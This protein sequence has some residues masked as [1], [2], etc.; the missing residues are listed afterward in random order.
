[1][2]T[3]LAT[4]GCTGTATDAT[5]GAGARAVPPDG[6]AAVATFA[7]G[8]FWCVESA[9]DDFRGVYSAVSGFAGGEEVDPTYDQVASG[10]TGHAEV[11]RITYDPTE[12]SYRDLLRV[13]W[14]QID[15]TD[16]GGQFADRG[17]QY[18]TA[19][20]YH[21][22]EQRRLAEAS[23]HDLAASG[24]FDA[25]I[26]TEIVPAGPFYPAEAYHQDFHKKNPDRYKSYYRGSGREGYLDR[27]WGDEPDQSQEK[28]YMKP[29]KDEIRERLDDLQ[30]HV[31]QEDGTEP[32]FRNEFWDNKTEGIYVDVVS[33][34]PLFASVHKYDSGSGWPSFWQPL[35]P[36]HVVEKTDRKL[37]MVRTEVRSKRGDSHLGHVFPDGPEP[38]GLRYCINSAALRFVAKDDLEKEGYGQYKALFE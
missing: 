13:F 26:V 15:P 11:V 3:I 2:L 19:I 33:G 34:E 14:R 23:K 4:A 20:F 10:R 5:A 1:M 35:E 18:R 32:P 24:K 7:G 38:T 29:S 22:E 30:Y 8:C 25:P 12:V 37:G 21:D 36:S 6:P 17:R 27:V 28:A 9:F 31:T 16:A